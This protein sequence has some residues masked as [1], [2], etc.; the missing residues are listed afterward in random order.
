MMK[1]DKATLAYLEKLVGPQGLE[2][3]LRLSKNELTD[4]QIAEETDSELNIVRRTLST[5]YEHRL[6]FY[7]LQRDKETGWMLYRWRVD[8]EDIEHHL[9]DDAQKLVSKLEKW[10]DGEQNTVYYTCDNHCSRYTF[11]MA[12]GSACG[13]E[14]VCPVCK[15]SLYHDDTSKLTDTMQGKISELKTDAQ[16]IF[17]PENVSIFE[18][19]Q[20][21]QE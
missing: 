18:L 21:E 16:A 11:D 3:V 7:T 9:A 15:Q 10:L 2:M 20:T 4:Q 5:L 19:A 12:S 1:K 6:A 8:F 13:Y 17:Y 14:F